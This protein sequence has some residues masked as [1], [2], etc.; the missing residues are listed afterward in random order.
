AGDPGTALERA[1]RCVSHSRKMDEDTALIECLT[2]A[3]ESH[4]ALGNSNAALDSFREAMARI[5]ELRGSII[6]DVRQRARF[7][8]R[9]IS[10][11]FDSADLLAERGDVEG[12]LAMAERA[13]GRVLLDVLHS[14]QEEEQLTSEE[15][16][17]DAE[18]SSPL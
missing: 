7:L 6:G 11:Y 13:K 2:I 4:R 9:S 8:E 3:G 12:A 17:R 10:P 15:Q 16:K 14:G 18:L 1:G 5:E